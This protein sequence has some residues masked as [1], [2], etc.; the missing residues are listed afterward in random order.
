MT[1]LL[2]ISAGVAAVGVALG[3][4]L[5]AVA[6]LLGSSRPQATAPAYRDSIEALSLVRGRLLKT[7]CLSDSA[8]Q[9]IDVLTLALVAGSDK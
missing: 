3:P 5:R 1:T 7:E 9:A 6:A 2:Q 4:Q 8:K